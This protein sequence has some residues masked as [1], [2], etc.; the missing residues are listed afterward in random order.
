MHSSIIVFSLL[1]VVVFAAI[2]E[3]PLS[4]AFIAK[5]NSLQ[6]SWRAGRNFDVNTPLSNIKKYTGVKPGYKSKLP[7]KSV[8]VAAN[9]PENF[10]AR[11]QWPNCQSIKDIRDQGAC[12]AS[13]AFATVSTISDRIC[14]ASNGTQQVT[15]SANDLISCIDTNNDACGGGPEDSVDAA[16]SHWTAQGIVSGGGY[17]SNEGCQTY[18]IPSCEHYT[19]GSLPPCGDIPL[20]PACTRQCDPSSGLNYKDDLNYGHYIYNI[21][22]NVV[23]IKSE[24]FTNGP[25]SAVFY[26]YEDFLSYK[27]GVYSHTTG[28]FV[29]LH[30][31]KL[32]GWGLDDDL[33][34]WLAANSWNE[35][36]GDKGYFKII[37]GYDEG[38]IENFIS[39]GTPYI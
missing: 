26:M 2:E 20:P 17:G 10:D 5:I 29:G 7:T 13:W 12:D 1:L 24:I 30:A 32:L 35:D 23:H 25:V 15:L 16:W 33:P 34:Y 11:E 31:V 14:I 27:S 39:A 28:D 8:E 22:D 38:G 18:K 4:D 6:N 21:H 19:N 3:N 37:R 9:L 36:W